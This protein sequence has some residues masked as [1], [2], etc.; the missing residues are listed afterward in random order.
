MDGF[1]A[2]WNG[3]KL[4]SKTG[5][6]FPAP[7]EFIESLPHN[8]CLDGELWIGYNEFPKLSSILKKTRYHSEN[9]EVLNLWKEVKFCVFDAPLH[10]GNYLERHSFAQNSVSGCGPNVTVIPIEQCLGRDH[11][12]S[13]LLDVSN[14]KGEGI[15]LYHPEAPYTSGRTAHLLKVK[16]YAE[17][18][19]TLIQCNPN[20]YSYLCEQ[21]NGVECVVKCSG[22]DYINPPPPGTTLTVRHNG[23]FK[24]SLKLKYPFLL[25]IRSPE[26]LTSKHTDDCKI[27]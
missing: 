23:Y 2:F 10:P 27:H 6:I 5:N 7:P 20:S 17:E 11:L 21:A 18:D 19:V 3:S 26:D 4:F 14:K 25:R 22:W 9:K 24:T 15:M 1:R 8:I 12:Q 16:A 13:V